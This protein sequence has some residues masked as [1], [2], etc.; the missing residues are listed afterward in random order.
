[1]AK[2]KLIK[3]ELQDLSPEL[4]ELATDKAGCFYKYESR[5]YAGSKIYA[6]LLKK[7]TNDG[8]RFLFSEDF[9]E[10]GILSACQG[11]AALVSTVESLGAKGEKQ[12][13]TI[14]A[15]IN[16]LLTETAAGSGYCITPAPYA[17]KGNFFS[18]HVYID[19]ATWI[20]S[21][22]LGVLRLHINGKHK[23][24]EILE[25][26]EEM[27]AFVLE[28]LKVKEKELFVSIKDAGV[29]DIIL[30]GEIRAIMNKVIEAEKRAQA[31]VI[32]RREE[33]ASTRSL[34]NTAKLMDENKTLYKLKELEYAER[35]F[36][37]V[38]NITISG[39]G[40]ILSQ[41]AEIIGGKK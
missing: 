16:E 38:G 15:L 25:N 33:V 34:L 39:N 5:D 1:M 32:T 21:A 3:A 30:P 36:E 11:L 9:P 2:S 18:K 23:L 37:N 29:K 17:I 40:D 20:I 10:S 27:S 26:K 12:K 24:D 7:Y 19:S 28:T 6:E 4:Q 41:L 35:I 31:N 8:N 22:L 14:D 13:E